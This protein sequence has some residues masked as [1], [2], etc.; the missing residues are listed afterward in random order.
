VDQAVSEIRGVPASIREVPHEGEA[1]REWA[2]RALAYRA[3]VHD[4]A[5]DPKVRD[6]ILLRC[7]ADPCYEFLVVGCIFEPRPRANA[8]GSLRPAGWYPWIPYGFQVDTIRWV[9]DAMNAIPGSADARL[10]RGDGVLEKARG[11]AGSWTFCGFVGNRWRHEDGFVAGMMSYKE[12]LVDKR[13]STDS[14]FYKIKGYLGLDEKVPPFREMK[15]G[16]GTLRIPVR[17]PEWMVPEGF[18]P[19]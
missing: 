15:V 12:D 1:W 18:S 19:R 16:N 5:R 10:G 9:E 2:E 7:A 6:E 17:P 8:D 3:Q 13:H 14:L 4:R 11:M